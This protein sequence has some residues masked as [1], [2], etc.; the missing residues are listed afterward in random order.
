M[1]S[2]KEIQRQ[3]IEGLNLS[4]DHSTSLTLY[5]RACERLLRE[6]QTAKAE[7]D[8]ELAYFVLLRLFELLVNYIPAHPE[9]RKPVYRS[10]LQR[11]HRTLPTLISEL[12]TLKVVLEIDYKAYL[13]KARIDAELQSKQEAALRPKHRDNKP[14][15]DDSFISAQS[16]VEKRSPAN[17]EGIW[18]RFDSLRLDSV[19][20]ADPAQVPV[21]QKDYSYPNLERPPVVRPLS[22]HLPKR[23]P[24]VPDS[25]ERP[26]SHNG[27][28]PAADHNS[29]FQFIPS[30]QLENGQNLK[31]V[32]VPASL[33][34][35]FLALAKPNTSRNLE[36]CGILSGQLKN[37]AY[38]VTTLIVPA[39]ASTS[40]T[41]H[42]TDEESLFNYQDANDLFTL[43][44]IHTHP[45]QTC[46]LSSVD[47]HTHCSY[48]LMLPEAIAIVL[49]PSKRPD[50]G[51]FRLTDPPGMQAVRDCRQTG[52]FHPHNE[53]NIYV[54]AT[55]NMAR[56][57]AGHMK[58][59]NGMTF[60]IIDQ[61]K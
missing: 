44:W 48:Q 52:L 31:T 34:A 57:N 29:E 18:Q 30:S 17:L 8:H 7:G 11:W 4:F 3:V 27:V 35:A 42:T 33:R 14:K 46:F 37:G 6:S 47:V 13:R 38:F 36:T 60:K 43:G 41:C 50:W 32:F 40:D 45:S 10:A 9:A 26:I 5:L 51:V 16:P 59:L 2:R 15:Y 21:Q 19:P 61:R 20:S 25:F 54:D 22:F 55:G 24:K 12:D 56:G 23:P 53:T 28:P 39:Q 58:E 1:R 49:A